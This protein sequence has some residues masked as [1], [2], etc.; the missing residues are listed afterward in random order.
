M[1]K[2]YTGSTY[3]DHVREIIEFGNISDI[4]GYFNNLEE[5]EVEG[6]DFI[7]LEAILVLIQKK[8]IV[9]AKEYLQ[10]FFPNFQTEFEQDREEIKSAQDL[11]ERQLVYHIKKGLKES[12]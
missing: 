6:L 2:E 10:L 8:M 3:M 11:R 4:T 1:E 12:L 7:K 5:W 9:S